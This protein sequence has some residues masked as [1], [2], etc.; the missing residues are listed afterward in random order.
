MIRSWSFAKEAKPY[1]KKLIAEDMKNLD[2][3]QK[4]IL[5]AKVRLEDFSRVPQQLS[6]VLEMASEGKFRINVAAKEVGKLRMT[7]ESSI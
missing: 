4:W 6:S 7:N 1:L 3:V 5:D 2:N